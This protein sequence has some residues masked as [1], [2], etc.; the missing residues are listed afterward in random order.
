MEWSEEEMSDDGCDVM[1]IH[2]PL[3]TLFLIEVRACGMKREQSRVWS[4]A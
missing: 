1:R 3:S 2:V 4:M